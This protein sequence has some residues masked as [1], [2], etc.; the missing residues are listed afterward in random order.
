MIVF[1][2]VVFALAA[3]V[4]AVWDQRRQARSAAAP[5]AETA[6]LVRLLLASFLVIFA[7]LV[8]IR[9]VSVEVRVFAYFKNLALLACFLGFGMGCAL[10]LSA[11]RWRL[12]LF[13][14]LGL[15]AVIRLPVPQRA[16]LFEQLS[17]IL[18]SGASHSIWVADPVLNI[19]QFLIAAAV[20]IAL[21]LLITT[22]F[23]PLGQIV[24]RQIDLA[25][26]T[27]AAYSW[28]LL[29]SLAG[30][31]LFLLMSRSS[32][33]P[34][35]WIPVVLLGM[36]CLQENK[37][38]AIAV[39]CLLV[40]AVMLIRD[41]QTPDRLVVWTPYQQIEVLRGHFPNGEPSGD[42]VR[43]N[44]TGYQ[45]TVN[46]SGEFLHRH[47]EL[48]VAPGYSN[49]DIAYLFA[50]S[51]ANVL[52]VGSGTGNDAAAAL[53]NG[54][55]HVDAVEIDPAIYNLGK[56]THPE[57]PYD[58]PRVSTYLT[59]ARAY[60]RTTSKMYD[61][62]VFAGLDSHTGFSDYSN[63]R[64]DNFVYTQESFN[65]AKAHLDPGGV[66]FVGFEVNRPWLGARLKGLLAQT[67][68][69]TPLVFVAY[70]RLLGESTCFVV[71]PSDQVQA[72][73]AANPQLAEMAR[74]AP[75][76]LNHGA[77]PLTTDDWPYL[78]T[79]S[80][81]IPPTYYS[82][83]VLL[84][85][86]ALL[87]YGE[88]HDVRRQRP[89]VFFFAMGAGFMLIETQT[90]SRLALFFGTT[91]VVNGIVIGAILLT[92]LLANL[93]MTRWPEFLSRT[94][95][96]AGLLV[97]LLMAY[98]V[99]MERLSESALVAG[100][101]ASVFFAAPVFFAGLLFAREF[102]SRPNPAA[103]LGS[104][105][106]GA[107]VGGLLEN[108]SFIFGMRALLLIAVVVYAV[109][110]VALF[111]RRALAPLAQPEHEPSFAAADAD[112]VE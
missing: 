90:I 23:I 34:V 10:A 19:K 53:R 38:R 58:S 50:K 99:P 12:G 76:F 55:S 60:L 48:G 101:M 39:A 15:V 3:L 93:V 94:V 28:N 109:A 54:S 59:D 83:G 110:V 112:G 56:A 18:G 86:I 79:E 80:R 6:S 78:Y 14:I 61:L 33:G 65:E 111:G 103:A 69:K 20:A 11:V 105:M 81:S 71:S 52:I 82:V 106:L 32:I 97:T 42:M 1:V 30:I 62:I 9:W 88:I 44:H 7:E 63:M 51:G 85:L 49:F 75:D 100:A 29:A 98:F 64:L 77:V 37:L 36:A 17:A 21:L 13:G 74:H 87:L 5:P 70:T 68:S 66:L 46:L 27:L 22:T 8:V 24:S 89:S 47:P 107:V 108:L 72:A 73:L 96:A 102:G 2:A 31:I 45:R 41:P 57:H 84:L 25:P 104:N 35:V 26:R 95:I 67:F 40:P 4:L 92:L 91:W 16:H 43:V